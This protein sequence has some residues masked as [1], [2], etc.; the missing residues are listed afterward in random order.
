[1][2]AT[3]TL[4]WAVCLEGVLVTRELA[5]SWP[6]DDPV[7]AVISEWDDLP[8]EGAEYRGG[9]LRA[10]ALAAAIKEAAP[11]DLVTVVLWTDEDL[12]A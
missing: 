11:N 7:R 12:A 2:A 4:T 6:E 1:M 3:K 8:D 10:T 5:A 9:P